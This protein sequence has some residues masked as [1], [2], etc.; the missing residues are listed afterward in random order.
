MAGGYFDLPI[1]TSRR[2]NHT[3]EYLGGNRSAPGPRT[4]PL[5]SPN[6]SSSQDRPLDSSNTQ[7]RP[8]NA[9]ILKSTNRVKFTASEAG[10]QPAPA[11]GS[12]PEI[13]FDGRGLSLPQRPLPAA[14]SI[15]SA[16]RAFQALPSVETASNVPAGVTGLAAHPRV[17]PPEIPGDDEISREKGRAIQFAQERAQRLASVLGRPTKSPK[18]SPRS[19]VPS[20][21]ASTPEVVLPSEDGDEIPM[22]S[23]SEKNFYDDFTDQDEDNLVDGRKPTRTEEAHQLVRQMTRKDFNFLTRIRAPSSGLRSGQTTPLEERDPDAYVEPPTHYRGGILS[24]LLKL[25]DQSGNP[26][27]R[28]RYVHSRQSSL[29]EISSRGASP[30]SG[31]KSHRPRKWYE[32]SPSQSST[33]LSGSTTKT[34]SSSPI[35]MLKRS[36][37]S[38]PTPGMGK[39]WGKPQLE[40]EI[41][42]T[43]HIAELLS[44]QRYLIRL[45]RALMKYGA[46]T[47]RLE[48]YMTMTARVL[49][50]D[51]QFLYIPGCMIISF[52]DAST[53]TTE[54]KVVRSPQG[55]DLG[56]LSDVHT[57]YKEVIH[58]VIGVEEA[59]QRLEEV[60]KAKNKYP[61]WMLILVHGFASMSV[62][63]FAFNG[64]PIDM[65]IA[66][67]LGC[68]LGVLQ[69]VLSPRSNLYS[70][71]FEIS[72]AVLTS[73][74]ARAFGSIRYEGERLFCF[75]ALA[76][77]SI[78]LILP[79][80]MVLCSSLELQ[81]RSI[82][83]GSVRMVYAI[84][85]SLFL[86]FGITI[87]TA[88][89]GLLDSDASN[90]YTCPP[91]PIRNEYLQHFPFVILFT[92]CLAL[93]NQ[94]KWKQIPMMLL[95]AF[96]G[97]VTNYFGAKRFASST[98]VSSALGA[99]V[100]GVLG[101][102]YSR[103]R[104]GLAAAAMLPAIFV[105]VPSGLAASGSLISGIASAQSI[106]SNASPYAVISNGT[107]G[108]VDAARNMTQASADQFHGV[109]FDIGYGMVQVA[110][111][112]TVGLFLAAL[113]VYPLGKKRSGLFSF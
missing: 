111:G 51:G 4:S 33:S 69:L 27:S 68:L 11:A 60:M 50:I 82:V 88:V 30:D 106:T 76:Q 79:G 64:R 104:H 18:P 58:D 65:P 31:W 21:L 6:D 45:C 46:P 90:D 19:S 109:V 37:S 86:G 99:F 62:A 1:F 24:S 53:H 12:T 105:L 101:N 22:I 38:G 74:L 70:N 5:A 55:V 66:F 94:A 91:S 80:Y 16:D 47:H 52:D 78:A 85:Y 54:V 57:I 102:L 61:V 113:V 73:F 35:A 39:R 34:S 28:G 87:G 95:I 72:A 13:R 89:Y 29:G 40:D 93:V 84:I 107:Q 3:D 32:K 112:F 71:V 26:Y 49:E 108:F 83:A 9:G 56:K 63:P 67:L 43:V 92:L 36:R 110:I 96:A 7:G 48:E 20:S 98:Q 59:I 103:L 77:S 25:H 15:P 23:L 41:R 17:S 97:Y 8:R 14:A 81:S 44:R 2:S 100:I 10:I 42:I 75:S